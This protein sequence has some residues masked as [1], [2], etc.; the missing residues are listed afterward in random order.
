MTIEELFGT[1]QQSTVASWRKHLRTAK[2]AKHEAL[3]EFY[4]EMPEK[5]DALIEG[6]MGAHGKKVKSFDNILQSSNM[7]TLK[8]LSELKRVCKEGY[9]LMGDNDELKSLLDDIVNL[10]NSTLY[11]VKELA[12]SKSFKSLVEYVNESLTCNNPK[13]FKKLGLMY[14]DYGDL[15]P[16]AD[17][18]HWLDDLDWEVMKPI[19]YAKYINDINDSVE[20]DYAL[21]YYAPVMLEMAKAGKKDTINAISFVTDKKEMK[22]FDINESLVNENYKPTSK[23]KDWEKALK[24]LNSAA[25]YSNYSQLCDI[26]NILKGYGD[27]SEWLMSIEDEHGVKLDKND[28]IA[29]QD[30]VSF[31]QENYEYWGMHYMDQE[32][33]IESFKEKT[34]LNDNKAVNYGVECEDYY[35]S[36]TY[37]GDNSGKKYAQLIAKYGDCSEDHSGF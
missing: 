3:D 15:S 20:V 35:E 32:E 36:Y 22:D 27:A 4:K 29:L 16:V 21:E 6:W 37:I 8:Y 14:N 2:Y 25:G 5:V 11:K 13:L 7:N 17:C 31:Y 12:E 34:P 1:L 9:A 26:E 24:K 30:I 33:E 23:P 18:F 10:I 28:R 19:Q